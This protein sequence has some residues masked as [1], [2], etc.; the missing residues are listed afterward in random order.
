MENG[1]KLTRRVKLVIVGTEW[2]A[3]SGRNILSAPIRVKGPVSPP[4]RRNW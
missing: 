4:L 2:M 1:P 3:E